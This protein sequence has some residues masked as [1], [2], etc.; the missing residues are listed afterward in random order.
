MIHVVL[1]L[2]S[3]FSF[4]LRTVF[5]ICDRNQRLLLLPD[6][7]PIGGLAF[8]SAQDEAELLILLMDG[9]VHQ[10]NHAGLLGFPYRETA[11]VLRLTLQD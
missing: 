7:R 2:K 8:R 5:F 1:P 11:G 3:Y 9:V 4:I 6:R 10:A